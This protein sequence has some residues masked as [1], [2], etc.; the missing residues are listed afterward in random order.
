MRH[1]SDKPVRKMPTE[2]QFIALVIAQLSGISGL[3]AAVT[4]VSSYAAQ[5]YDLGG[6]VVKRSTLSD[7]N[8][9]HPS[10]VFETLFA[11]IAALAHRSLRRDMNDLVYSIDATSL[12]LNDYSAGWAR[13][14]AKVCGAKLHVIYDPSAD[15]P[16][17]GGA[18]GSNCISDGSSSRWRSARSSA[19]PRTPCAPMRL[20]R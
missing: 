3:R 2:A 19:S 5:L 6:S 9:L 18:G 8:A 12:R 11:R 15:Q 14:S 10:A 13:F 7:A 17:G 16:I 20:S 4:V 1:G